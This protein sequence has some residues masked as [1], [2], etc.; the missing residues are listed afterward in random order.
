MCLF[1]FRATCNTSKKLRVTLIRLELPCFMI[2]FYILRYYYVYDNK[3]LNSQNLEIL[4]A[5]KLP[6]AKYLKLQIAKFTSS[7]KK[8]SLQYL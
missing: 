5:R 1:V 6:V 8:P 4:N 3:L 2:Y 7:R